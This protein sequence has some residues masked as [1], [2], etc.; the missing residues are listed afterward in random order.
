ME[1]D[2]KASLSRSIKDRIDNGF[3]HTHKPVM[4]DEPARCFDTMELY[5]EWCEKNL[6][7][8]LG[9]GKKI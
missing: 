7:T 5:R 6:P 8:W 1:A 3:F 9:Y 2:F 4:D